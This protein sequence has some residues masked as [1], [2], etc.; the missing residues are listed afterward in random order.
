MTA[1]TV[2][3]ESTVNTENTVNME[4]MTVMERK[5]E[6]KVLTADWNRRKSQ[7]TNTTIIR[8]MTLNRIPKQKET[9]TLK[10]E[11]A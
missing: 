3:M 10:N 6:E 9:K 5:D 11:L 2:N 8:N 4:N 7:N 1:A